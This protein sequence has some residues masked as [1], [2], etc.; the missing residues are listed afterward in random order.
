MRSIIF[1]VT[2]FFLANSV[3]LFAQ[4]LSYGF[5]VGLNFSTIDG[6]KEMNID[7]MEIEDFRNTTGFHVGAEVYIR[8]TDLFGFRSGLMFYQRGGEYRYD[9]PGY[10]FFVT[11]NG[12]RL[13]ANGTRNMILSVTNSYLDIPITAYYKFGE[14]FEIF[15]G[16]HASFL[17]GS[18]GSGDVT[19]SGVSAGNGTPVDFNSILLEYN[20]FRDDVPNADELI[21]ALGST[22]L[23]VDGKRISLPEQFGAYYEYEEKDG[24]FYNIFDVGLHGGVAFYLNKGLYISGAVNYGLLDA[25]NET[26]DYTRTNTDNGEFIS[27]DDIDHNFTIQASLGFSF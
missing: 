4:E 6:P 3:N 9:G 16:A 17:V 25:T 20:F 7:G 14:R 18:Q 24:S 27:R 21:N 23:E 15:G 2:L 1:T 26:Y 19:F 10:Q 8:L 13:L 5:K 22:P 12:E 11:D